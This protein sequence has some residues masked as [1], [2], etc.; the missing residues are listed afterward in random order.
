VT[1][2]QL[3]WTLWKNLAPQSIVRRAAVGD[4]RKL[5]G[6]YLTGDPEVSTAQ[7]TQAL[8]KTRQLAASLLAAMGTTG[9][10]F[11]RNYLT[12][13]SPASIKERAD[14]ES[15]FFIGPEQKCWR[16]YTDMFNEISGM[17]IEQE[18]SRIIVNCAE[19]LILGSSR[20]G[21][22]PAP[23]AEPRKP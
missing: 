12:R 10:T 6:P 1:L 16:K 2:D 4:L 5:A 11:A 21:A 7:I 22:M 15:G 20:P 14:A 18:I 9:E 17:Q 8:D 3:V 23:A 19:G 13:F